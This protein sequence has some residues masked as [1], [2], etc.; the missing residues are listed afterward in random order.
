MLLGAVYAFFA[1]T[2]EVRVRL[3]TCCLG[4]ASMVVRRAVPAGAAPSRAAPAPGEQLPAWQ[5]FRRPNHDSAS[6]S[7]V[8]PAAI[9]LARARRRRRRPRAG[10][11]GGSSW[12]ETLLLCWIAVPVA[13]FEL[14]PV[15]GFQYLLPLRAGGRRAGRADA[16]ARPGRRLAAAWRP[17]W[18][19]P[20]RRARGPVRRCW[21]S[22]STGSAAHR[23][24]SPAR[25]GC[26]AAG[27]RGAGSTRTCPPGAVMTSARRWP[28]SCRSTGTTALGLSVS[29]N[30]LSRNPSYEPIVNPDLAI[31]EASP[32]RGLGRVHARRA[33]RSSP[34]A[35]SATSSTTT[36]RVVHASM[37][38]A[39]T[40]DGPHRAPPGHRRLR[41]AAVRRRRRP[42]RARAR[43]PGGAGGRRAGVRGGRSRAPR[44]STSS[45]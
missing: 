32:V 7:T 42:A 9:G 29:P 35:C 36:A 33:R 17:R 28:T 10:C 5:L 11:A 21:L 15:K 20:S 44:S 16:R 43:R 12:R 4:R 3:R 24:S 31:R 2:P 45:S 34:T 40:A 39:R 19:W 37:L 26:P 41:G 13:F 30:P 25:A 14:W 27:R 1:L 8:V 18:L 23:R 22:R 6:T 38:P